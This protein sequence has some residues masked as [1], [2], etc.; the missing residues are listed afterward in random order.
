M[1]DYMTVHILLTCF[2]TVVFT[3]TVIASIF[4]DRMPSFSLLVHNVLGTGSNT[5]LTIITMVLWGAYLFISLEADLP[6]PSIILF[7]ILPILTR[8]QFTIL[9]NRLR[10]YKY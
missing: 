7:N 9:S 6:K 1:Q 2:F 5:I 4:A 8:M 3:V 10:I